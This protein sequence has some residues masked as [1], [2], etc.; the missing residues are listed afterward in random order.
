M[1]SPREQW[2]QAFD[3]SAVRD[4]DFTTMSGLPV[5]PVYGPADGEFP[6]VYPYT[7]G[8]Y[9]SMYRSKVWTMRMFAGFGTAIDT[10]WRF[11]EIVRAGGDGLSTAFD[12]PTL[13][14]I[15]SDDPMSLGEVG[16]CGVAIDSLADMEDLYRGIDLGGITTSMTI[17][18]PAAVI[19]AMFVAQ[20]EKAG[21]PRAALGGTLQNDILKEYQAQKEFV[22]PP[23]PSMRLVRDTITFAAAEMPRWH[24]VS[25]SGYHIRE[26]GSTAAEELA[27]T[28]A[29]GFAYVELATKAGLAVDAFAPRLSF[30][31]NAHIDF[32]EE[33]AKY[34]AA[35]RIWARWLKERYGAT[36]PR[37]MQLRFHTQTAGV[38]LTAQQPEVNIVRTAI[39]ALAGVLGGT[40]SLHTNSMDEALALPTEK[41][42]RIALRTQQVIA[43]ETNVANVADPLGG[44]WYLED[45]TDRLEAEAE[46]IFAH[47][48]EI[49]GGSMLEGAFAGIDD[50]WFQ[51]RIADSAY[52]LERAFNEGRRTIVGVSGYTEGNDED[53]I[54]LLKITNEDEA[55]Q[56]KRL[57]EVRRQRDDSAV[58]A[59]LAKVRAD[60]ADPEVNLMPALIDAVNSYAT[61]GEVMATLGEVF[62][63]HVE[64]PTI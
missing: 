16:R 36:N 40:Q 45:L 43:H 4:R 23:R 5:D 47:L 22:F 56:L 44:S 17:N 29:N 25:I 19:F 3:S 51:R 50:N 46:E 13:L 12:M 62:G 57:D 52:E 49:G 7:R 21:T 8:P 63:R 35:R 1:T 64:V 61:L 33:I 58:A 42:A 14:G 24:P 59:A 30:F 9:A 54:E 32:F 2:Q 53:Q 38:S 31:F 10:N 27:F 26:A 55:R 34:R 11:K 48:D 60:A 6:G 28:L 37:S 39:E 41:A 20:A 18:S 15:D